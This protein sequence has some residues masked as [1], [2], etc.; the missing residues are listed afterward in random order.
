LLLI[1]DFTTVPRF[2]LH[3]WSKTNKKGKNEKNTEREKDLEKKR[4]REGI[5]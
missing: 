1:A 4:R 3:D 5:K 2:K